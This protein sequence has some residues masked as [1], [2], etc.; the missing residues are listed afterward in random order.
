MVEWGVEAP[1]PTVRDAHGGW[2]RRGR[3][4]LQENK[5]PQGV[6]ALRCFVK[7]FRLQLLKK[8]KN[9]GFFLMG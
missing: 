2:G 6:Y 4:P 7:F 5:T 9:F 3:C 1:P 8:R